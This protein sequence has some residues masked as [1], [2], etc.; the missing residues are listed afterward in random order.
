MIRRLFAQL[1]L[2]IGLVLCL[3]LV[4]LGL[5]GSILVFEDEL[6]EAFAP[7]RSP[8]MQGEPRS[9]EE[10]VGAAHR[11]APA[12]YVPASYVAP[13]TPAG[14]AAVRLSPARRG[15]PASE[16]VRIQVD[17]MTLQ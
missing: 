12:D 17:P 1:H 16:R 8:A 14:L 11:A 6:H 13:A 9:I 7:P 15:A 4:L 5:T 3:P 10:I 2:W